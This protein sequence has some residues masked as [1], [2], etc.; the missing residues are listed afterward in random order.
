MLKRFLKDDS[1]ATA[2]E[3]G[4]LAALMA[5]AVIA[6]VGVIGPKIVTLFTDVVPTLNK[7]PPTA[8]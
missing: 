1:G 2:I 5:V 4:I 7:T 3:Y 8:G 6:A